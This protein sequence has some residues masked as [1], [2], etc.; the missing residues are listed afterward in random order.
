MTA[1]P[2]STEGRLRARLKGW[3]SHAS[4]VLILIAGIL[5]ILGFT[6][7]VGS[8]L[9]SGFVT[10][11][12]IH[13]TLVVGLQVFMGN[14][15]I[16]WFPHIGFMGIGAYASVIFTM[17]PMQKMISL[18]ELYPFLENV[19]MPFVPA[20]LAGAL[21]AAVVAAV[22]GFPMM[23]LSDF[24]AVIAGFALLVV[25]HVVLV[26][27]TALTNGPQTLFGVERHTYVS[28]AALWAAISIVIGY[29][30]K[31]SRV[32]LQLRASR[33]DLVAARTIGIRI[34]WVRWLAL[35]VSAFLAGLGGG[36]YAHYI[37]S[38][39]PDA[40]FLTETFVVL[41]M[42]V[43]GGPATMSGA[44]VG[45]VLITVFY[46]SLRWIE[47][48]EVIA[49]LLPGGVGGLSTLALG[50]ALIAMLIWRP[51]GVIERDELSWKHFGRLAAALRRRERP[52]ATVHE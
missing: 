48:S 5:V 35:I 46:Q 38:F 3:V 50:L 20:L 52:Q 33:E 17:D 30:F 34:M 26:H 8:V 1:L 29:L 25:I 7:A 49:D 28:T 42:L 9:L 45:A 39:M 14:T 27:W 36:L 32:G 24:P 22:I 41:S 43:I 21:V 40:F 19:D 6:K 12:F 15:N 10:E 13:V 2:T 23:R 51:G 47:N 37:T 16:L 4:T 18:Q 11:M 31:E 44:L